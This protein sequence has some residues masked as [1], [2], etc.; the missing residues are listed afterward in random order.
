MHSSL[1][2]KG[3]I[4]QRERRREEESITSTVAKQRT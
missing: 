2:L 3:K 1:T 4:A